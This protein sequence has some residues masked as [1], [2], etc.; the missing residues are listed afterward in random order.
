MYTQYKMMLAERGGG[1]LAEDGYGAFNTVATEDTQILTES[2]VN[3]AKRSSRTEAQ[4]SALQAQLD[5]MTMHQQPRVKVENNA[6]Y[7]ELM[8]PPPEYGNQQEYDFYMPQQQTANNNSWPA[9]RP[10]W[11]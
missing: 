3:Y 5:A 6:V 10:L 9:S 4:V 11:K 2:L 1:T 8:G 7:Q